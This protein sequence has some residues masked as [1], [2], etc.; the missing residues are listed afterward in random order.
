MTH[1]VCKM[2]GLNQLQNNIFNSIRDGEKMSL[3]IAPC[4][5]SID[6]ASYCMGYNDF[7]YKTMRDDEYRTS[8]Y[9]IVNVYQNVVK[10][11]LL[12]ILA[13]VV[14]VC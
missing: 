7:I 14:S 8:A 13:V 4:S 5:L 10:I 2:K 3:N 1:S 6:S 12:W 11:K 9:D